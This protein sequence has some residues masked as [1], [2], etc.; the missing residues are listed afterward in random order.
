MTRSLRPLALAV[1]MFWTIV[2]AHAQDDVTYCRDIAPIIY[3]HCAACHRPGESAPFSLL[4][5]DDVRKRGRQIRMVTA[6]RYMP[7]WLPDPEV[8]SFAGERRLTDA[9][10]E[11]IRV[12]VEQGAPEGDPA[13]MPKPRAWESEFDIEKPDLVFALPKEIE[14]IFAHGPL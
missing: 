4:T 6:S 11:R 12:W 2:P 14:L 10:I 8:V 9:E 5:Y 3:D 1:S 7:P 13:D